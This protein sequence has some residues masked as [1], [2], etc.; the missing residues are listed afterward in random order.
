MR[1]YEYQKAIE[2]KEKII[3]GVNEFVSRTSRPSTF[4]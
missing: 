4:F 1:A 3:V 2:R